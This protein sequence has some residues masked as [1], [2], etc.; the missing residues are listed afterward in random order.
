MLSPNILDIATTDVITVTEND[1]IN[2]AI[3]Y[4]Y[5]KRHRDVVI[6]PSNSRNYS[7]F[8][9]NDLI[10]L[11]SQNID[12]DTQL[13]NI[14]FTNITTVLES[15]SVSDAI[16]HV[17][18]DINCLCVVDERNELKGFVSYFDLLSSIDP[19]LM[20]KKRVIG[21]IMLST[22]L[23]YANIN[24][25]TIEI[26][27]LM[28]KM[29]DCVV[30]Q[31]DENEAQ[32]IITTKDI[33]K[34]FGEKHD[35]S[36]PISLYMNSPVQTVT[37]ETTIDAALQFVQDKHF[38]RLIVEDFSG[39]ILGQITQ[40]EL[41]A[42]IYSK[43]ADVMRDKDT[44]LLEIN[45]VLKE[46]ATKFEELSII[47]N[48]TGIHN[49]LKFEQE[50]KSEIER[51][52][53]YKTETFSI[54]LLDIDNFKKVNDTYG[55]LE[56]DNVLKRLVQIVNSNL[57]NSDL[58]S[59]W[60]GEEF[61]II[62]PLTSIEKAKIATENIRKSI[63]KKDFDI[64]GRV[65]CSFGLTQFQEEDTFHSVVIKADK[66]MYKAKTSGKNK[67]DTLL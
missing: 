6:L 35:L 44:Q 59:R 9:A 16:T 24:T 18:S 13:K 49:R 32:G 55:H 62:F 64:V 34:L 3:K 45:K 47:D 46:R 52:K 65:T 17:D 53:R 1:T 8:T 48:L 43:W 61:I 63:C 21:E 30:L 20:L 57:R 27:P 58:F 26:L 12:F 31:D 39:Q 23:K 29:S 25:P 28:D 38:K 10:K 7:I 66:A 19:K 14:K 41:L 67:V 51:F 60:G 40:E 56:G 5:Q 37:S 15:T 33:V 4:M 2:T 42:R 22:H 36:K 11:K 50:L 54:A